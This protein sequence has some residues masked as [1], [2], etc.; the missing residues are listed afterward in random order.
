[1]KNYFSVGFLAIGIFVGWLVWGSD[2]MGNRSLTNGVHRMPGGEVM[3]DMDHMMNEMNAG[4][5]GK[6]GDEFDQEFL[7]EMIVHHQG[8]IDMAELVLSTSKR[9]ELID[10]AGNI[11]EAQTGEI[12]MMQ[13]WLES[14]Y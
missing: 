3:M 1:M 10:L 12:E 13:G 8:A 6:T 9:P 2:T 5:V 7:E 14:W 4:L 11:I